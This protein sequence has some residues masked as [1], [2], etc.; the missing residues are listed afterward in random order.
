[1]LAVSEEFAAAIADAFAAAQEI[2][3]MDERMQLCFPRP[4]RARSE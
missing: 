2:R 4:S 3:Q 1:V